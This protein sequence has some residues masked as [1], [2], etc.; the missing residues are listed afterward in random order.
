MKKITRLMAVVILMTGWTAANAQNTVSVQEMNRILQQRK[1][2]QAQQG[3]Q[4]QRVKTPKSTAA[5]PFGTVFVEYNPTT[6]HTSYN[7]YTDNTSYQGLS[8]GASYF[9]PFYDALG[10]DF[11]VKGQYFFRNETKGSVKYKS[12]MFSATIPVDLAYDW[13][14]TD[15]LSIYPYAGL[16][17]RLNISATGK[18]EYGGSTVKYN[19]FDKDEMG[20]HPWERFQFGWQ[21]GINFRIIDMLTI[22]GGYWMDLN[23][24]TD[25]IK[26]YGFNITLGV[27]F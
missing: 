18:E 11:G 23:E 25:H 2:Q 26:L 20:G 3:S 14:A 16:Y 24:I 10:V 17:A 12:N 6:M 5:A 22:G 9:M 1:Q 15:G 21:A 13:H 8:L 27:N 19:P 7:G 4:Q